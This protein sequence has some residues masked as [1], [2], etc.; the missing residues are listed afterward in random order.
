MAKLPASLVTP[1]VQDLRAS[2]ELLGVLCDLQPLNSPV[3]LVVSA[4]NT[5]VTRLNV[6]GGTTPVDPS[7]FRQLLANSLVK[8]MPGTRGQVVEITAK[9]RSEYERMKADN[10]A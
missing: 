3:P 2:R 9:G 6:P 1:D 4:N 5:W 7:A 10:C 8:V